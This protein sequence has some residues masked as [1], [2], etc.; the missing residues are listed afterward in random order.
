M[1]SVMWAFKQLHDKGLAYE[2]YRCLPY[3]WND[4]TPLS[5]HELRMDE[6][7]YQ[8]RKDPA[9]TVGYRLETGGPRRRGPCRPTWPWPC[10]ATSTTSSSSPTSA[11]GRSGT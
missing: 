6:D 11:G 2:G 3:C 5:A 1:E 8:L 9:V 7:V 10:T 4:E